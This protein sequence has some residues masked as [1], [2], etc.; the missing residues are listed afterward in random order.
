MKKICYVTSTPFAANA[1]LI[2][3]LKHLSLTYHVTLCVNKSLYPLSPDFEKSGIRTIHIPITRK[4][5]PFIDLKNLITL[6]LLF[7]REKFQSVQTFTPKAGLLGTLAA[8]LCKVPVRIHIFTGQ[9]W[10]TQRYFKKIFYI[11]IDHCIGF[12]ASHLLCDSPSQRSFLETKGGFKQGSIQLVGPG[13]ISGVNLDVFNPM[14]AKKNVENFTFLFIGRIT[15]DKGI[16]DLI[17]AFKA[18]NDR[19]PQ[20]HLWV[21]GPDE[22]SIVSQIKK[23]DPDNLKGV[24]WFGPTLNPEI[25][26]AR[27]NILVLPSYREGFGSVIIEAAACKTPSIAYRIDGVIDAIEDEYSGILVPKGDTLALSLAML[28]VINDPMY[29]ERLAENA[30]KRAIN[31]FSS[32]KINSCWLDYYQTLLAGY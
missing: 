15:R 16:Y 7:K 6:I 11:M 5:S 12:F 28:S 18:V 14:A 29:L 20:A 3:K 31:K 19:Y 4:F 8:R 10:V 25:F 2:E 26:M 24:D 22:E 17:Q 30:Y 27:A 9:I 21:V 1:F 32:K 13:S 23:G